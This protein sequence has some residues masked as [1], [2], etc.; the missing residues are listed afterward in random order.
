M[1]DRATIDKL[2]HSGLEGSDKY[3]VD[4]QVKTGNI[5][6]VAIDGDTQVS[7]DDCIRLSRFIDSG[8]DRDIEDYELRVS[9]FGADKPLKLNRQYRK[10]IGR[11]FKITLNDNTQLTGKLEDAD[12]EQVMIRTNGSK[13]KGI[14][15]EEVKINFEDIKEAVIVLSFK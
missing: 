5:I 14:K 15:P 9:S 3:V 1:I 2:A 11:E 6:T 4:I 12:K 7:I 13:K 10:N 8:L